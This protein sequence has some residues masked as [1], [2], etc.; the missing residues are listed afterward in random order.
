MKK[1]I[2]LIAL[3][4]LSQSSI[5][6][7]L[8]KIKWKEISNKDDIVVYRPLDFK[9]ESGIVPIR[10]EAII[11][12]NITRVLSVLAD[13]QR[14]VEWIPR[15]S[16]VVEL[17]RKAVNDITVYYR[18]KIP[19]PFSDRDFIVKNLGV[20]DAK[21]QMINVDIKSVIHPKDPADGSA[22][23]GTSHDGYAIIKPRGDKETFVEMAFLNEMGGYMPNFIVNAAQKDW[24]HKFMKN[25]R[26]QLDKKDIEINPDFKKVQ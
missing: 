3:V 5:A 8:R 22:I 11:N 26:T 7:E 19:W 20:F 12:H 18:Y 21:T 24:P 4:L 15:A 23:R 6:S 10:F 14:K 25:L 16:K 1:L 13:N 2:M 9:H 17:E